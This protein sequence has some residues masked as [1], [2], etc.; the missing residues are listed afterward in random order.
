MSTALAGLIAKTDA[1][2]DGV[3]YASPSNK[4]FE[5]TDV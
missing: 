4:N 3:P 1:N 5:A 2:Y